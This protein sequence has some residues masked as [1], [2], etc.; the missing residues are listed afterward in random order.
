MEWKIALTMMTEIK[1][2]VNPN[3][4]PADFNIFL[5]I[6]GPFPRSRN[7]VDFVSHTEFS[8]EDHRIEAGLKKRFASGS[9]SRMQL[10]AHQSGRKGPQILEGIA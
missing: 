1:A 7:D 3:S 5:W 9:A 10:I 2:P 8:K 4:I 6:N